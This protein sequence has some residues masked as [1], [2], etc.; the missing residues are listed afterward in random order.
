MYQ[1]SFNLW[2]L[3]TFSGK[4]AWIIVKKWICCEFGPGKIGYEKRKK[5]HAETLFDRYG[6][7]EVRVSGISCRPMLEH[8]K[9]ALK[10]GS[11]T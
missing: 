7:R 1:N 11:L 6:R 8:W 5:A 4:I 9:I 10:E 3:N 2:E